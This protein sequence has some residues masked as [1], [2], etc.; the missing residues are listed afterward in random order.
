MLDL[1]IER[2]AAF[3][4]LVTGNNEDLLSRIIGSPAQIYVHYIGEAGSRCRSD[5]L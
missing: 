3:T 2:L 1:Y 4:D 5:Q